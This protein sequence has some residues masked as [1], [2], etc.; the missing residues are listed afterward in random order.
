M[1]EYIE[2]IVLTAGVVILNIWRIKLD[3]WHQKRNYPRGKTK[4]FYTGLH[5]YTTY[6]SIEKQLIRNSANV[7]FPKLNKLLPL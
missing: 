1:K 5:I 4:Q 6:N 7:G 2:S 3:F